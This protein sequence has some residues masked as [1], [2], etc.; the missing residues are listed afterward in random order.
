MNRAG[1]LI[2][3]HRLLWT[4][5]GG[6]GQIRRRGRRGEHRAV[7]AYLVMVPSKGRAN[8]LLGNITVNTI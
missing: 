6:Q 1:V 2:I 7:C 8:W 3:E 5:Q 4:F